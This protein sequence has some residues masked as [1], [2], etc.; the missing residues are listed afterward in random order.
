[1]KI[2]AI[3]PVYTDLKSVLI[4]SKS[5]ENIQRPYLYNEIL[6]ITKKFRVPATFHNNKIELP[7]PTIAVIDKLN[8]L[9]IKFEKIV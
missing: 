2:N 4:K 5:K 3:T 8:E 1:M 7:T 6:N 9:G